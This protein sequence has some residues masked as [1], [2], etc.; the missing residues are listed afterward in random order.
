[1]VGYLKLKDKIS[2][3]FENRDGIIKLILIVISAVFI[4]TLFN[5][6][7]VKGKDYRE[8][9]QKKILRVTTIEAP[10]GE[11][12]DRNGVLLAT[13]KLGFDLELYKTRV[14]DGGLNEEI[15]QVINILEKNGDKLKYFLNIENDKLAF[16]SKSDE[17]KLYKTYK[18]SESM[19]ATEILDKL[20]KR[21]GLEGYSVEDRFKI[22]QVRYNIG[23]NVYSLFKSVV[24]SENISSNSV[25]MIE[26]IKDILPG[27]NIK[28]TPKRY[29]PNGTLAAHI[30]G[31]V[32]SITSK[33]YNELKEDGYEY[34]SIIGKMGI[35]ESMEIYLKGENGVLR[36]E[37]DSMGIVTSENVYDEAN[38][39][40]NITLSLDYRLQNIAEQSLIKVI[41]DIREGNNGYKKHPDAASGTVVVLD[42]NTAEVLAM[43]SYPNFD[44]NEFIG[45]ISY[46]KWLEIKNNTTKPMFNRAISGTYSPG[47]T[48]KMLVGIAGLETGAITIDERITDMG[49]YEYGH[50][51]KCWI[52]TSYGITHGSINVS[53][54]IKVSCNC[55]FYEVG[56][57]MGIEKL[58]EYSK[59]FGL[60]DKTGIEIFGEVKG[61]MAGDT[62]K[63]WYLGDTL[64]AAIGQSY[65][66]YTPVQL[67]NYIATLANGGSLNRVRIVQVV[68]DNN[69]N[70][71]EEKKLLDYIE[72]YT[73]ISLK[74][75]K[76]N[77]KQEN[78]SAIVEGMKS[79]TSEVGGTSYITFKNSEIEVAGKTGT[80]QVTSG[81]DNAIF[82]GFAPIT[83]PEIAV[84]AVIE[85]GGS[86]TY[87]AD[88]VKPIMDEYFNIS[89]GEKT[90]PLNQSATK[91]GISY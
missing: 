5:L 55:F 36:T 17:K 59:K 87:T 15:L 49:V 78:I 24:I 89:N 83:N 37:V 3:I 32:G 28:V 18:F 27:F 21:Y 72:D 44:P 8:L 88:V 85:H 12:Y 9:S 61:S 82:V 81:S 67:A 46:S 47:S 75:S 86:G 42:T 70:L 91:L 68:E 54:A 90:K 73:S 29:Y 26:E 38:S 48:Y 39:G 50:H 62:D 14:T 41:N 51:P 63:K 7:V 4:F 34:N 11:I 58:V 77:L 76:L 74:S 56:R 71:I 65:N 69:N 31:Y 60:G 43:A 13:N 84:V 1:M 33:E 30:L 20:Y 22:L 25:T 6:Q 10:R 35:E 53:G 40:N 52:Y 64:S 79:V 2:N 16:A 23:T 66:S 80:A 45:G 19:S 57:R